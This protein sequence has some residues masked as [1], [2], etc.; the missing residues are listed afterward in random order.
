[1]PQIPHYQRTETRDQRPETRVYIPEI[2]PEKRAQE[3]YFQKDLFAAWLHAWKVEEICEVVKCLEWVG[4]LPLI[5][6]FWASVL[7]VSACEELHTVHS[8]EEK[9]VR[10]APLAQMPVLIQ[11]TWNNRSNVYALQLCLPKPTKPISV[12]VNIP[13]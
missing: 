2:D 12:K 8:L 5:A 1:L 10:P 9:R 6:I 13:T 11:N 4:F 3:T 7:A